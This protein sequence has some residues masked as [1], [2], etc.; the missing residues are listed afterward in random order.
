[1]TDSDIG[2]EEL[3][4]ENDEGEKIPMLFEWNKTEENE[5]KKKSLLYSTVQL[6]L[7]CKDSSRS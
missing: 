5:R 4:N 6:K 2:L 1:M 3:K 7:T